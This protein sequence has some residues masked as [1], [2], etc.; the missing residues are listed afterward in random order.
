MIKLDSGQADLGVG[1]LIFLYVLA[2]PAFI[3][4]VAVIYVVVLL[5]FVVFLSLE[6]ALQRERL[7]PDEAHVGL[8]SLV[9][10]VDAL[11]PEGVH[12]LQGQL[13]YVTAV[14]R[15]YLPFRADCVS[16]L[17]LMRAKRI[18]LLYLPCT[19]QTASCI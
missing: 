12:R 2:G 17:D 1:L 16:L 13:V 5:L 6:C 3:G 7:L 9:R 14:V 10:L 15:G 4:L 18:C 19:A 8:V 11:L